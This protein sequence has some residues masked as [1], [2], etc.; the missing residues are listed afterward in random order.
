[1]CEKNVINSADLCGL[2][3][4]KASRFTR[5]YVKVTIYHFLIGYFYS[6]LR[7]IVA[8]KNKRGIGL[9]QCAPEMWSNNFHH[10]GHGGHREKK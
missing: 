5:Q 9:I 2:F 10:R 4:N 6:L 1:M 7:I 3:H 8:V